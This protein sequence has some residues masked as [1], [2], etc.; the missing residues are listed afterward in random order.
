M[1]ALSVREQ[2]S[3]DGSAMQEIRQVTE[4]PSRSRSAAI[5]RWL[6]SSWSR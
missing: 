2:S 1:A 5:Y 4:E 6:G 3:H